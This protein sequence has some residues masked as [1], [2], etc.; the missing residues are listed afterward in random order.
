MTS[1]PIR[2]LTHSLS[3]HESTDHDLSMY[4]LRRQWWRYWSY[5]LLPI[6]I[7]HVLLMVH[8]LFTHEGINHMTSPFR[9]YWSHNLT[10]YEVTWPLHPGNYWLYDFSTYK[11]ISHMTRLPPFPLSPWRARQDMEYN[12]CKTRAAAILAWFWG[13]T[14]PFAWQGI[15]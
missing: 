2:Y 4:H 8:S 3:T 6:N 7:D 15:Y 5:Y 10:I 11:I 14:Q 12:N 13:I 1:P 9:R